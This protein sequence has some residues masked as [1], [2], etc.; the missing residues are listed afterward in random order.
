VKMKIATMAV[1]LN[2]VREVIFMAESFCRTSRLGRGS[3]SQLA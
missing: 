2:L 1:A 3:D